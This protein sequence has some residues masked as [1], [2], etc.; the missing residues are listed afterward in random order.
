MADKFR[1]ALSG[2]FQKPVRRPPDFDLEPLK[3]PAR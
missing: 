2:D 1:V 3:T